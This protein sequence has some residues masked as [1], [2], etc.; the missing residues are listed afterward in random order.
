MNRK[1]FLK[2]SGVGAAALTLNGL[3]IRALAD[4]ANHFKKIRG[5]S[6]DRIFV[7][8][9]LS[10]GNDGL[11][12]VIP[13]DKYSE[14][15]SSRANVMI[16]QNA[17]LPLANSSTTGLHPAM[18][19][20]QGMYND[21]LINITQAVGYADFNYS[22]FRA[23]DIYNSSSD[24]NVFVD[25]GWVGR[26]LAK[27]FPG[28]PN[29]YPSADFLDPL[30]VQIGNSLSTMLTTNNGQIGF[31]LNDLN[32]FYQ[33]VN[34]AVDPAPSTPA[35]HELTFIRY[36]SLQTQAYTQVIQ[37]AATVGTNTASVTY[38]ANNNLAS[39]LKMVAKMISGGMKTP[40]YIV[41]IGGFDTHSDQVDATNNSIGAHAKLLGKVS[42][43][44]HA[45]YEDLK[46]QGKDDKVAGCTITEF[47]RRIKSNSSVGTDHGAGSPMICFGKNVIPGI[48]GLSP[49]IPMNATVNDQIPMQFDFRQV[50]ASVLEDWFGM[51]AADTADVLN[52]QSYTKLPI[53]KPNPVNPT[54]IDVID[55]NKYTL[56]NISV[57]PNPVRDHATI[58]FE[59]P[60]GIAHIVLYNDMGNRIKTI[61]ESNL[62]KGK[63]SINFER[64]QL[65]AGNYFFTIHMDSKSETGKI[66]II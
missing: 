11:N 58:S 18:T 65:V 21:G 12:T 35:G 27:V 41:E 26:Y 13:I 8:V 39:Q 38:P 62:P 36:I 14:L 1:D 3:P 48:N 42:D 33:I 45:F 6:S 17:V 28:A 56:G 47:G 29:A 25:S 50:Y 46:A 32:S 44:I 9:I 19:K 66:V 37:N 59:C 31:A 53:F 15:A 49:N 54:D 5:A 10:G 22:H 55:Y 63:A 24:A 16:P 60:G 4:Q 51:S 43:A 7:F 64:E 40:F 57:Y 61:Y 52:G 2:A 23:T 30:A 20:M 34:G